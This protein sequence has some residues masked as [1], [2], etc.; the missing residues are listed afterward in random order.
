VIPASSDLGLN[1]PSGSNGW[2]I[3]HRHDLTDTW[4]GLVDEARISNISR[5]SNWVWA[6]WMNQGSNS[7]FNSYGPAQTSGSTQGTVFR[8]R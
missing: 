1:L 8:F 7:V 6:C 5:S 2:F 3:G 4:N